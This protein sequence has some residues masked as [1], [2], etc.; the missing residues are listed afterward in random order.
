MRVVQVSS[1]A[2]V[3]LSSV[4]AV[5][6]GCGGRRPSGP[7]APRQQVDTV[8]APAEGATPV[9]GG[10]DSFAEPEGPDPVDGGVDS[11]VGRANE[12]P[13]PSE[14]LFVIHYDATTG[15]FTSD[16]A[17]SVVMPGSDEPVVVRNGSDE[18]LE[19][20]HIAVCIDRPDYRDTYRVTTSIEGASTPADTGTTAVQ[21]TVG[22]AGTTAGLGMNGSVAATATSCVAPVFAAISAL[23]TL[24]RQLLME[25]RGT[26]TLETFGAAERRRI[27]VILEELQRPASSRQRRPPADSSQC[28]TWVTDGTAEHWRCSVDAWVN[29]HLP[30]WLW[31]ADGQITFLAAEYDARA[32]GCAAFDSSGD[33]VSPVD[34]AGETTAA[35]PELE[36]IVSRSLQQAYQH[37]LATVELAH[38]L[39]EQT[40][41]PETVFVVG[42]FE[43]RRA[44]TLTVHRRRTR[45]EVA[46]SVAQIKTAETTATYR[47]NVHALTRFRLQPG[48]LVTPLA[49][50]VYGVGAN[51]IGVPVLRV[52]DE[53]RRWVHP[54]ISLAFEWCQRDLLPRPARQ[55]CMPRSP[56]LGNRAIRWRAALLYLTPTIVIALPIDDALFQGGN[57]FLGG[58]WNFPY[59]SLGFGTHLASDVPRLRSGFHVGDPFDGDVATATERS[60]YAT[61]FVS[62]TMSQAIFAELRG[63]R[64]N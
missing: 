23:E 18:P 10:V 12:C 53:N 14:E 52:Q 16:V 43:G 30:N 24:Q 20:Q 46:A 54:V 6:V 39:L 26:T 29:A 49:R 56:G 61:W 58:Q 27:E 17:T 33:R 48:F 62:V 47:Q 2:L 64:A 11:I 41:R 57:F 40:G 59:V 21:R 32:P 1:I 3:L 9:D 45:L 38:S 42:P 19:G 5:G 25:M 35:T 28:V 63:F 51:D 7:N 37:T 34:G 15:A 50:P 22:A 44:L 55:T 4:A 13:L 60:W 31:L 36:E 8:A